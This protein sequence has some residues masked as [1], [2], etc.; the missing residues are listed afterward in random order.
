MNVKRVAVLVR[1]ELLQGPKSFIFL[2]SV[3]LPIVMSGGEGDELLALSGDSD[4][5]AAVGELFHLTRNPQRLELQPINVDEDMLILHG[6]ERK[7]TISLRFSRIPN[8]HVSLQ[9]RCRSLIMFL[10]Q[11]DSLLQELVV[12]IPLGC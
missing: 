6:S 8:A 3:V 5:V 2:W 9:E 1:R 11:L 4:W 12:R 10:H 7:P